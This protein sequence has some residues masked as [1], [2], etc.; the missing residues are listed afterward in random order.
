MS[1]E[2]TASTSTSS[3]TA[4]ASAVLTLPVRLTTRS[5][6][7]LIPSDA[8]ILPA[9]WRRFQ[10]SALVN[11]ILDP[12]GTA[13]APIPFDFVV[14]GEL[15]Q[16]SLQSWVN[17]RRGGKT[18]EVLELEFIESVLPPQH[19]SSYEHDDWLSDVSVQRQGWVACSCCWSPSAAT[20]RS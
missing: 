18:E 11:K 17:E 12:Q 7:Y 4:A 8:F 2:P 14:E 10:L 6:K 15:L 19:L 3:A 5:A 1:A 9:N 20:A 13:P 16:G